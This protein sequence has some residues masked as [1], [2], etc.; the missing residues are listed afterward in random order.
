MKKASGISIYGTT[1]TYTM[2]WR[3]SKKTVYHKR[4]SVKGTVFK[5]RY[6]KKVEQRV[7][8]SQTQ[9]QRFS[10]YGTPKQVL[11]CEK[12]VNRENWIPNNKY[13]DRIDAKDFLKN[14]EVFGTRS[15]G[16]TWTPTKR[17][18]SP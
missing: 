6:H 7:R 4:V 5:Q 14:P 17:K 13:E 1:E 11:Q 3:T 12:K 9:E 8:V 15:K 18:H 2:Q 10:F 16:A